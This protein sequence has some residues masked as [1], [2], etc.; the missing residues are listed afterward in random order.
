MPKNRKLY[1]ILEPGGDFT[2]MKFSSQLRDIELPDEIFS[3]SGSV[4]AKVVLPE[5]KQPDTSGDAESNSEDIRKT[6]PK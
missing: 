3:T 6:K 2:I 1:K 4:P 5:K